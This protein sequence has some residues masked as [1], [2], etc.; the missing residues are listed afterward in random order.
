VTLIEQDGD[1]VWKTIARVGSSR[2]S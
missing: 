1:G 2:E